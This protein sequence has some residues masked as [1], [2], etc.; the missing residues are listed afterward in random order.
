MGVIRVEIVPPSRATME[1]FVKWWRYYHGD[2][3]HPVPYLSREGVWVAAYAEAW[4]GLVSGCQLYPA[5]DAPFVLVEGF[6]VNPEA[7]PRVKHQALKLTVEQVVAYCVT[8]GRV[9]VVHT[10]FPSIQKAMKRLGFVPLNR[11]VFVLPQV[12]MRGKMRAPER[13]PEQP[14]EKAVARKRK[15]PPHRTRSRRTRAGT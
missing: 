1:H 11:P 6:C 14:K 15:Q 3:G 7:P 10:G 8:T 4:S 12:V 2:Q 5:G 13:K 9:P